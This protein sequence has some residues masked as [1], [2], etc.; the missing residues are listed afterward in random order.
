MRYGTGGAIAHWQSFNSRVTL[1][2][3]APGVRVQAV[4]KARRP[5]KSL[6]AGEARR[7]RFQHKRKVLRPCARR[8]DNN[9]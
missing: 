5:R 7:D 9:R 1:W 4:P 6:V 2:R 8:R 3:R